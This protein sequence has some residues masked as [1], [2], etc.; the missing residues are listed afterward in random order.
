RALARRS[1]I[2]DGSRA[3]RVGALPR[4]TIVGTR[5]RWGWYGALAGSP[6]SALVLLSPVRCS[7][8]SAVASARSGSRGAR[9]TETASSPV[10]SIRGACAQAECQRLWTALVAAN[11]L[12]A[13]GAR[14]APFP[15]PRHIGVLCGFLGLCRWLVLGVLRVGRLIATVVQL[16][17]EEL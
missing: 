9:A 11:G 15:P 7:G 5:C 16:F 2:P 3:G 14:V 8:D 1:L 10:A 17:A 6:G 12:A 4:G 13:G